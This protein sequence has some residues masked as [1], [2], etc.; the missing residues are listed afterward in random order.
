MSISPGVGV[1]S[2]LGRPS[3]LGTFA[4]GTSYPAEAATHS[5]RPG[6]SRGHSW[7][8]PSPS[9]PSPGFT[10]RKKPGEQPRGLG[11]VHGV[12]KSQR[13]EPGDLQA[14]QSGEKPIGPCCR[15]VP[16]AGHWQG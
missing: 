3:I 5:P 11:G 13:V 10:D 16:A 8:C 2:L 14:L 15:L 9:H 6:R 4:E 12:R 1:D 7:F